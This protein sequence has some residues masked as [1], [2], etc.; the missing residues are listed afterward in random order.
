MILGAVLIGGRSSRFGSNKAAAEWNGRPLAEHAAAQRGGGA[1]LPG[2][3]RHFDGVLPGAERGDRFQDHD[4]LSR[5][6]GTW[7]EASSKVDSDEQAPQRPQPALMSRE[8]RSPSRSMA[9]SGSRMLA[10]W[11][12]DGDGWFANG[13]PEIGTNGTT[14]G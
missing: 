5:S 3:V 7:L 14:N 11:A 9:A 12:D 6:A 8:R 10:I 13:V 1:L 2:L 4:R